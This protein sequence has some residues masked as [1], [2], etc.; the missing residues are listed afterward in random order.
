MNRRNFLKSFG[1]WVGTGIAVAAV[2]TLVLAAIKEEPNPL[3][4]PYKGGKTYLE[5]GYFYCPYI[6]LQITE[7]LPM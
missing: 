2:P 5:T 6:P 4:A 3:L 7:I 1:R